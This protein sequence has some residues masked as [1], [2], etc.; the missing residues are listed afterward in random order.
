MEPEDS[1]E[2]RLSSGFSAL[3]MLVI[4]IIM[5]YAVVTS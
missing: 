2:Y 1:S 3:G 5:I 4:F